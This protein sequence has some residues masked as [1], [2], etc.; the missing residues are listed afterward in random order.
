[1]SGQ[2]EAVEWEMVIRYPWGSDVAIELRALTPTELEITVTAANTYGAA[3]GSRTVSFADMRKALDEL[4]RS[5]REVER[6]SP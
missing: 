2:N 1:M 5:A 4:E 3:K 6:L